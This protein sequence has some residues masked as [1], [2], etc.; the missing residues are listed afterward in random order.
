MVALLGAFA[1]HQRSYRVLAGD[2]VASTAGPAGLSVLFPGPVTFRSTAGG[3]VGV[4][5]ARAD[6]AAGTQV[7]WAP[8]ER[9]MTL[10]KGGVTFDVAHQVGRRFQ[11]RTARFTVEVVGTRFTVDL[12]GVRTQRGVVRVLRPSGALVTRIEAGQSWQDDVS[13]PVA[14]AAKVAPLETASAEPTAT[15]LAPRAAAPSSASSLRSGSDGRA[16][17][18]ASSVRRS[19]SGSPPSRAATPPG[20]AGTGSS[21]ADRLVEARHSLSRGDAITARRLVSPLFRQGRE[22][23]VEARIVFAESFLVEGRY[24]DAVDAYRIVA[25]DFPSSDQ[26]ETSM[27]AIAQ[28]E[29][30]HGRRNDAHAALRDYVSRYP[31]GRFAREAGDRLNRLASLD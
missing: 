10:S 27:F 3:S 18:L 11:V 17:A 13:P 2:V 30:E 6:L 31:R 26:A 29:S 1:W 12:A 5:D 21:L 23:A 8:R 7:T 16:G 20:S 28:L 15:L 19:A 24:A 25:R 4:G 22:L 9:T 14:M